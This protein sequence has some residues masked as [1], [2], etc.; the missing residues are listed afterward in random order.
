MILQT[1][2]FIIGGGPAGLA[3]ALA[4]RC[5]GLR[6]TVAD[7]AHPPIDKTCGEGLMP[8]GLAA[9]ARL[10][11]ALGPGDAQPFRGIRFVGAGAT[12]QAEFPHGT[13]LGVRRTVLHKRLVAAAES[14]GVR[15]LW[16]T[17]VGG[18]AD[19]GGARW[20]VG[21]DG[22]HSRVRQWIG[23]RPLGPPPS[24]FG[25]R[26]HFRRAPWTDY[27]E[28]HWGAGCQVYV[29][30]IGPREICAAVISRDSHLRLDDVLQR[31]PRLAS[32]LEG[33]ERLTLER[34]ALTGNRRLD[35]VHGGNVV[36]AGDASGSVDAITGEGLCLA[37]RQ[38]LALADALA[39]GDLSL[40]RQAHR[41][42]ARR[43]LFMSRLMLA[44]DR[45]PRLQGAALRAIAWQPRLFQ[46]LLSFHTCVPNFS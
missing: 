14:A 3:V 1:D 25:F 44:L 17:P 20:I 36:L 24:R 23:A 31:F 39:A 11:V 29:T 8:D 21:A 22:F 13:A 16:N 19:C 7:G 41:T 33:A 43:P 12:V 10:G 40:Y 4:A 5:K 38:S 9:L 26:I 32:R 46:T 28:L 27:M 35:R 34:G 18:L 45:G 2:V 30:P 37:F 6:V 42:L 15:M